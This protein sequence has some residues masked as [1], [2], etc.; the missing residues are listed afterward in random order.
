MAAPRAFPDE[1]CIL[2][3]EKAPKTGI[4]SKIFLR[5]FFQSFED[6]QLHF[7]QA[8]VDFHEML[9]FDMLDGANIALQ[10]LGEGE[11]DHRFHCASAGK[12]D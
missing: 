10:L 4:F 11:D 8:F 6:F 7:Q 2:S 1:T 9:P 3:E 5:E 12:D